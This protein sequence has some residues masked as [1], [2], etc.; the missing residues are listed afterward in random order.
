M[1]VYFTIAFII[2]ATFT[3]VAYFNKD[4]IGRKYVVKNNIQAQV[5][6]RTHLYDSEKLILLNE[7]IKII[8]KKHLKNQ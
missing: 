1:Y 8:I 5:K 2:L 7:L 4:E 6:S 3:I